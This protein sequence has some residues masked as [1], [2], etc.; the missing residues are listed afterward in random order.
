MSSPAASPSLTPAQLH[1]SILQYLTQLQQA[2][3]VAAK[4]AGVVD[5]E[6]LAV[7]IELI[8]EATGVKYDPKEQVR[9]SEDGLRW[10]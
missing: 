1:Q 8:S 2:G 3:A 5:T 4:E 9:P 10:L 6:P 7:A